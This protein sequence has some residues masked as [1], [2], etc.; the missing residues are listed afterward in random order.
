[1]ADQMVHNR[2][3]VDALNMRGVRNERKARN[4]WGWAFLENHPDLAQLGARLIWDQEAAGSN[5]AI[6]TTTAWTTVGITSFQR[7]PGKTGPGQSLP[8]APERCRCSSIGRAS[9][10]QAE[11]RGFEPRHRLQPKGTH[12]RR[13]KAAH[14]VAGITS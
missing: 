6:G 9:A 7:H 1:M 11:G 2:I 14:T 8:P 12:N 10:F 4:Q 5:P 13:R 3:Q